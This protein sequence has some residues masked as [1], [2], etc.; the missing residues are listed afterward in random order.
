MV[1]LILHAP[2]H[3][4]IATSVPGLGGFNTR[5]SRPVGT[6]EGLDNQGDL[7]NSLLGTS[8]AVRERPAAFNDHLRW[9]LVQP[10][11]CMMRVHLR[12]NQLE[13]GVKNARY[14]YKRTQTGWEHVALVYRV[15]PPSLKPPPGWER[16]TNFPYFNTEASL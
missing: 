4:G 2:V 15:W 5:L 16:A 7:R 8:S 3:L 12:M 1:S 9:G 11:V 6:N 10:G 14:F 13:S